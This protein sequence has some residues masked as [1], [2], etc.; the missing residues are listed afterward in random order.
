MAEVVN[1]TRV[2][3]R[4]IVA[5]ANKEPVHA[6][7][8]QCKIGAAVPKHAIKVDFLLAGICVFRKRPVTPL[9]LVLVFHGRLVDSLP[10][11]RRIKVDAATPGNVTTCQP[12]RCV[13]G[14]EAPVIAQRI[15]AYRTYRI[16]RMSSKYIVPELPA[17]AAFFAPKPIV[18]VFT[19]DRFTP[20]N[21]VR[22]ITHSVQMVVCVAAGSS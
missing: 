22:S 16:S 14:V 2:R 10:A 17:A 8:R 20:A 18:I 9:P 15:S 7:N 6:L 12:P 19:L 4:T 21:T 11:R 13:P 5:G 1:K 3:G